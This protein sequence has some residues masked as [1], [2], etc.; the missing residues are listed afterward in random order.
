[1]RTSQAV[2]GASGLPVG[3]GTLI[4]VYLGIALAVAWMLHRL[5]GSPLKVQPAPTVAAGA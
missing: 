3:Y 1:M 4:A 5:A 2:T